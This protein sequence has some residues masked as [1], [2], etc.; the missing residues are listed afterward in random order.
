MI[1]DNE[2]KVLKYIMVYSSSYPSI[3]KIAKDTNL[4]PNGAYKILKKFEAE[5]IINYRQISNIKSYYINYEKAKNM[6]ELALTE[7]ITDKKIMY[8]IDDLSKLQLLTKSCILFGSYIKGKE[9]P[10]D[11]DVLYIIEK[12]KFSEFKEKLVNIK[13]ISPVKIHDII[14]SEQ[15]LTSNIKKKEKALLDAIF[16]G[17]TIWGQK[18]I[19]K[20]FSNADKVTFIFNA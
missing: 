3:N 18:T 20:A 8:R 1:T 10:N 7:K 16:T 2:K 17:K 11:L 9:N 14:Q 19:V 15:D 13:E 6:L 5:K 12:T 4:S